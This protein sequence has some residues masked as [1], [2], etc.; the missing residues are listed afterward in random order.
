MN[1]ISDFIGEFKNGFQRSSRFVCQVFIPPQLALNIIADSVQPAG[2]SLFKIVDNVL[3]LENSVLAV[4]QIV[5]WLAQ[6]YLVDNARLPDRGFGV[7]GLSMYGITEHFPMHAEYSAFDCNF[8]MPYATNVGHDN[9][10]PRFFN[11]WQNQ[12]QRNANGPDSGFDFKFPGD[13]YASILL[14][15]LDNKNRGTIT[16]KFDRVYPKTVNSVQMSWSDS[17]KFA[18]LPVSFNF[19]YWTVMPV[20]ESLALSFVDQLLT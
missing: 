5:K 14:T 6:G 18:S 7:V 3:A 8:L 2:G 16:Y 11:Y 17:D 4:P 15:A 1:H 9:A 19:S 20:A 12:M 13:Y 10:V